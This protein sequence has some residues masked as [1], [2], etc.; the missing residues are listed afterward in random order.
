MAEA[1]QPASLRLFI[2]LELPA[3]WREALGELQRGQERAAPGHF[4]WVPPELM[5]LTLVFLGWQPAAALAGAASALRR[6]AGQ[7]PSFKLSLGSVGTFGP[8]TDPRVLWVEALQPPGRLQQL[9]Q[10]LERELRELAIAFDEKPLVPHITLGR[11]RRR[12]MRAPGT[13]RPRILRPAT[14]APPHAVRQ[15]VLFESKLSPRG[16]SYEVRAAALLA[17]PGAGTRETHDPGRGT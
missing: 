2:A 7:V 3:D 12:G 11:G 10:A 9:R 5:H 8:P 1:E 13:G 16:P 17:G 14:V 6:A 4:R 15:I